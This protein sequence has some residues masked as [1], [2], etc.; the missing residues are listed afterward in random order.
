MNIN[1]SYSCSCEEGRSCGITGDELPPGMIQTTS[2]LSGIAGKEDAGAEHSALLPFSRRQGP[3]GAERA[4]TTGRLHACGCARVW[5]ATRVY[6]AEHAAGRD[7]GRLLAKCPEGRDGQGML[8]SHVHLSGS[9]PPLGC[10]CSLF[11]STVLLRNRLC[12]AEAVF[13]CKLIDFGKGPN[14]LQE[15]NIHRQD[16]RLV[17]WGSCSFQLVFHELPS[18]AQVSGSCAES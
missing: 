11:C 3:A 12:F 10:G 2:A 17:G 14:K 15:R 13:F 1:C 5:A 16:G 4:N 6:P 18:S 8:P 9:S 7:G